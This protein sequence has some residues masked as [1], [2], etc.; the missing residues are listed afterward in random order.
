MVYVLVIQYKSG[1][2]V[3]FK[4]YRDEA[5]AESLAAA[6]RNDFQQFNW[7]FLEKVYV[8]GVEIHQ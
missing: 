2:P 6:I 4:A 8:R 5:E 3:I 7:S 1:D